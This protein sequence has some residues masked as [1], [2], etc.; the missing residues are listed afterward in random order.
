VLVLG[1]TYRHGV[2]ELAYSR[3]LPLIERLT[4]EGASVA[5]HDPLLTDDEVRGVGAEP[6]TWGDQAAGIQAIVTQ[7]ADPRWSSLDPAWFPDLAIVVDG[8]NSLDDLALPDR[9]RRRGIGR[10]TG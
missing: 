3:A 5:A 2:R 10:S 8:R 6:W 4:A 9:V 1:L 7:T